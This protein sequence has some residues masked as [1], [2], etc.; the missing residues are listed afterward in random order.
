MYKEVL[1]YRYCSHS[2]DNLFH[3]LQ[4]DLTMNNIN[5]AFG[6]YKDHIICNLPPLNRSSHTNPNHPPPANAICLYGADQT[7]EIVLC[8]EAMHAVYRAYLIAYENLAPSPDS[9]IPEGTIVR[10]FETVLSKRNY[11]DPPAEQS[12]ELD[13]LRGLH[14]QMMEDAMRVMCKWYLAGSN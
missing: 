14:I 3:L 12:T 5:P 11:G 10:C 13:A 7:Y 1:H 9:H 6:T 4:Q 8:T 2:S